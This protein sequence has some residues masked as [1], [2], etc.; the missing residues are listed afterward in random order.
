MGKFTKVIEHETM[1]INRLAIENFL[2]KLQLFN[3]GVGVILPL[4]KSKR[5]TLFKS[6]LEKFYIVSCITSLNEFSEI[7]RI[8]HKFSCNPILRN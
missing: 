7:F 5:V 8:F 2:P 1:L 4:I 3:S 6:H